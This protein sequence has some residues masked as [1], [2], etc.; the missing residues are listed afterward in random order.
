MKQLERVHG[1]RMVVPEVRESF[2]VDISRLGLDEAVEEDIDWG[3]LEPEILEQEELRGS[4]VLLG[5]ETAGGFD[6]R[7]TN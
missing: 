6:G 1:I 2:A 4:D 5:L 7:K 3:A